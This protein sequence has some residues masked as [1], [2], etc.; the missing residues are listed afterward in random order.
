MI[1]SGEIRAKTGRLQWMWATLA[2]ALLVM[3]V[4]GNALAQGSRKDDI[5]LGPSGHPIAGATV[6]V[7]QATAT[8]SPCSPLATLYT[9]ATLTVTSPNPL[10][11]DGI[12][13][14]HFYA[15][16][17][18][19]QIQITGPGITGTTTYRD[20]ILSP[21][22]TSTSTGNN[23]SAFGLTLGGNLSVA[24][25]ATISGT[26][27]TA[28]FSPGTFT[29]SSLSVSGNASIAGPRPYIDVT[30]PPYNADPSGATDSTAAIQA[31]ITA[32]CASSSSLR[33]AVFFP[34]GNYSVTQTQ[35]GTSTTAPIFSA[36]SNLHLFGSGSVANAGQFT[37]AGA[38]AA[39]NVTPGASPNNAPVFLFTQMTKI[40]FDH[41][42]INAYNQ[43]VWIQSSTVVSFD[44]TSLI[45]SN[46]ATPDNTP[47]KIS[48][49]IWVW[50]EHGELQTNSITQPCGIMAG[51][52]PLG[53]E[54]PVVG[55]VTFADDI[56]SCGG[57]QFIQ[58]VA[59]GSQS[60]TWT[61]RNITNENTNSPFLNVTE[62]PAGVGTGAYGI[63]LDRVAQ[64]DSPGTPPLIQLNQ[65]GGQLSDVTIENSATIAGVAILAQAGTLG[66]YRITNSGFASAVNASGQPIGQGYISDL[67]ATHLSNGSGTRLATCSGYQSPCYSI[68]QSTNPADEWFNQSS[69]LASIA[70]DP[71]QGLLFGDSV[72]HGYGSGIEQTSEG[73]LDIRTAFLLPP[74][75]FTGTATTGGS[76]T[77]GTYYGIIYASSGGCGSG[78][79]TNSAFAYAPGV[80]VSGANNAV[81]FTW[82]L[83]TATAGAPTS[84]CL[85]VTTTSPAFDDKVTQVMVISGGTTSNFLYTGQTQTFIG[86]TAPTS[87][88]VSRHRFTYNSLGVNTTTPAF[89]LDVNGSAAVNSLNSVQMAERFTGSDAA[90]Q[91]NACLTAVA[92]T[93]G[94][95]DARG[96]TGTYTATHHIS[97]PAHTALMWCQAKLTISDTGTNDAVELSGDGA[98][99]YGCGETGSG[100]VPRP[101]TSG[102][103]ACGIAGCT[104]V[105]NPN[106][107]TANVD[108]IHIEKMYLQ[109]TGASSTVLNM[110]S[111]GHAD[112]EN[113][114]FVL[115]TGNGSFGVF[116]NTS[117]G[118]KDSTNSLIKH[119]EI[120]AQS[121]NDTCLSL[122]GVFNSIKIEQNSC[123]LPAS[124]TGTIG[125][126]LLKDTNGNYP[127]NDEFDAND[128]EASTTSF[129]Q[130]CFNVV[131]AQNVQIGPTNR[132]EDVYNC[133]QFPADG[134]AVGNHMI[135]PYLSLS[136]NTMVKPNEPAAA[137]QAMD[138]T[139][140]NWQPSFHYGL[141]DLAG[142]NLLVNS[143]F[144]GWGNS[145]TLYGW[146]GVSG[147]NINQAGNGIYAQQQSSSA[148]ID[149]T[150]QGSFSVKIGDNATAGLGVNSGC[151]EVDPTMNYTL[152]FRI[153]STSTAVKFRPGFR[154]YSD[155]NCTEANRITTVATNARVLQPA[156]YAGT[157]ALAG[158]GANWQ[159]TNASLTYNNGITCN[160][161]V[162]G[163]DWSLATA[164]TWTP[165]RNY[166]I[167]FRVPNAFSLAS[168]TAQSMRVFILENTAANPNQVFVDDVALSQGPVSVRVPNP[169]PVNENGACVGCGI[170]TVS[171]YSMGTVTAGAAPGG[172]NQVDLSVIYVPNVTF[173]HI[174]VDVSTLDASSSDFYS[175]AITDMAGNVKCSMSSAV[176]LTATGTNQQACSQGTVTLANGNYLFAFTGNATTAKIAYSGTA[177]LA[178]STAVSTSTSASGVITF[179]IGLPT[180][181]QT[182]SSYGLPAII[183]N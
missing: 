110:T 45:V 82:T 173:S 123:Y 94:V 176:N 112:I 147:T 40:S 93:S 116:G 175:W 92:S 64:A 95:C 26:L 99:M 96:L 59:P 180:A 51:E 29:P 141:N 17:G 140:T 117:V 179:P 177:P 20:V 124:N 3:G 37:E 132:C 58:R 160:C 2:I 80:A 74:T 131:G 128:C 85:Q 47:L 34:S 54:Q 163:A 169:G 63:E 9:D 178:L 102:Y 43:A 134:S 105:D 35:T 98:A 161:N 157:S 38:G 67:S 170:N 100:T 57:I 69:S 87:F 4:A 6:R 10:Q 113:N 52:T 152:A 171:S 33:P 65:T 181:G 21:D 31:A 172:A 162:T 174:T 133:I 78:A 48:N 122:A 142:A 32:A 27:T 77:A 108:W 121:Q 158:T 16:A 50:F 106:A 1:A 149:G 44:H 111:V 23:I 39:I 153:A 14:Y 90:V 36:C 114:R 130:I 109:A 30:A 79:S 183:L 151:I 62:S 49:A 83:P 143:G 22:V 71:S 148:P 42:T 144:E 61:F 12:G 72:S 89:N 103:I 88:M 136:V 28:N 101:Q 8:G 25:N 97:I 159:S 138:N 146:G 66:S 81:N 19:Y 135:D 86:N 13:N 75:S 60:G 76:L 18:R 168:T 5:V 167:T 119:N 126:A 118:N 91:I 145:T 129:G 107:A 127:D 24:G 104:T 73:T 139:G 154:F 166:A 137:Q 7:C 70:I 46:H 182:F 150:T 11:T 155:P 41:L 164:N 84:Y 56:F 156:F 165:T 15:P 125:F 68:S 53:T 115:G 120:D 55:I